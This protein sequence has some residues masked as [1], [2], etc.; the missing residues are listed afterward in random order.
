MVLG[1][2]IKW[3]LQAIIKNLAIECVHNGT[4][5][6]REQR[7]HGSSDSDIVLFI[8]CPYTGRLIN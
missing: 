3:Y 4:V 8:I 2:N 7:V 5:E 1:P 6:K